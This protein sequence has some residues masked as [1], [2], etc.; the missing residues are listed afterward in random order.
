MQKYKGE[1]IDVIKEIGVHLPEESKTDPE[2]SNSKREIN[3]YNYK[4]RSAEVIFFFF[5]IF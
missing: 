5:V 1:L 3:V 2:K 4:W